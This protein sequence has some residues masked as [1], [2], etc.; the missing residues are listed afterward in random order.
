MSLYN[1]RGLWKDQ[2]FDDEVFNT[3]NQKSELEWSNTG[4]S[5]IHMQTP[6]PNK[7]QKKHQ[8]IHINTKDAIS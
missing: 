3:I 5:L 2:S 1:E 6:L 8:K 7:M 4:T